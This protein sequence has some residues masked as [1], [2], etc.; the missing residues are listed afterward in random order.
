MLKYLRRFE[1][2]G[3]VATDKNTALEKIPTLQLPNSIY[4][5]SQLSLP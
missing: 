5:K 3:L 2:F 1:S 4:E